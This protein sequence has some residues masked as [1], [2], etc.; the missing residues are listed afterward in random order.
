MEQVK[1]GPGIFFHDVTVLAT[2]KNC[3]FNTDTQVLLELYIL[4]K[5][6]EKLQKQFPSLMSFIE[7]MDNDSKRICTAVQN[8]TDINPL[9]DFFDW[10][11]QTPDTFGYLN[12]IY[13]RL[14]Y[15][16]LDT[17]KVDPIPTLLGNLLSISIKLPDF[18][19]LYILDERHPQHMKTYMQ[20]FFKGSDKVELLEGTL[21]EATKELTDVNFV[22]L[23]NSE[24]VSYFMTPHRT[25][26]EILIPG[27][28]SN[29]LNADDLEEFPPILSLPDGSDNYKD[30]FNLSI[31]SIG[32]PI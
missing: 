17:L 24:D 22:I 20:S 1:F 18:H 10:S 32:I 19:K 21:E 25:Q 15:Q 23:E 3:L 26:I 7:S 4:A 30:E 5:R 6:S 14:Y 12:S 27:F 29:L 13:K 8:K 16:E 28:R 9:V 31:K 11:I 2:L